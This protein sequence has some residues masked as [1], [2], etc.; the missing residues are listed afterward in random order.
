[1]NFL[2]NLNIILVLIFLL[3]QMDAKSQELADSTS[4]WVID[5]E[6]GNSFIGS[7]IDQDS[8]ILI[9]LT[10]VYGQVHIPLSQ[11]KN[12]KELKQ[13]DLIGGEHWFSNPHATRYF[14]GTNGYGL[15]KGEAY[16]QNTWI[17]FNQINYGITNHIS[18]GGGLVP[19]F[20]FAGAPTPVFIT[21][22]VTLPVVKDKVNLGAGVLYAYVL[23]EEF[24]FGITYGTISFGNR[25]NNLTL[26]GGWAFSDSQWANSP[27]LTLSGMTR[28]GRKTY[29]LTENYYIGISEDSS[30]G[31]ISLGGRSVQKKLAVDYG[32]FFPVGADIGAF[33]AIPW[34][35]IAVPFGNSR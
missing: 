31:I 19:L 10:D 23:G 35:G 4:L 25:D 8:T 26:G 18:I 3:A 27:T 2:K 5:T 30:L 28:V 24:G 22:K 9:L 29:L 12:K 21:P 17:L 16:Y 34:L 6:D 1:M 15:R 11:V 7:I 33:I 13:T 32:L 14:F 20:L